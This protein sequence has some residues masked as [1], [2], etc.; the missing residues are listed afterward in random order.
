MK[1]CK[2]AIIQMYFIDKLRPKDIAEKL[3]ISK[4]AVSQVLKK[5]KRY[6]KEK[7]NRI[8]NNKERHKEKTKNYI[9]SDRKVKQFQ[10]NVDDLILKSMHNQASTELS[11]GK[12]LNNMAYRNWNK[13][14][15]TYNEKR[16]GYEFR[17]ELGRSIDVPEFIKVEV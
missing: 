5:D 15:Y 6:A 3:N 11:K 16:K 9:K 10:R 7:E 17:K 14:A 13:S 12:R 2:E 4:S 1:S 8:S